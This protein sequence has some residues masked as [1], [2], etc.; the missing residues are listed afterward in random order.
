[1]T[2]DLNLLLSIVA[3]AV[4]LGLLLRRKKTGCLP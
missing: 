1:M 2:I 4:V 3:A